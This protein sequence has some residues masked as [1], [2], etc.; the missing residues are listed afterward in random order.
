[1]KIRKRMGTL[2]LLAVAALALFPGRRFWQKQKGHDARRN[3][4]L[5]YG[6]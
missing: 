5:V 4:P 1:M 2:M 6:R 3:L